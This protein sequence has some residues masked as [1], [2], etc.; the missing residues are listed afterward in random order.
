[1][2]TWIKEIS[3]H[4]MNLVSQWRFPDGRI[5]LNGLRARRVHLPH[6]HCQHSFGSARMYA[7]MQ[8]KCYAM[9]GMCGQAGCMNH[10]HFSAII[11]HFMFVSLRIPALHAP[12]CIQMCA[13][14]CTCTRTKKSSHIFMHVYRN[15]Q[16]FALPACPGTPG[17]PRE[18]WGPWGPCFTKKFVKRRLKY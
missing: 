3:L 7:C 13:C 11:F 6:T 14:V 12:M 16:K 8:K 9:D 10:N 17:V 18:P 4:C 5:V 15:T 1:M 2:L